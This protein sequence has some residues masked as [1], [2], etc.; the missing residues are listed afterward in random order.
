MCVG[1]PNPDQS[2]NWARICSEPCIKEYNLD[3]NDE[4]ERSAAIWPWLGQL[5][6]RRQQ[7]REQMHSQLAAPSQPPFQQ[8]R[9]RVSTLGQG[10][11][12]TLGQPQP[13]TPTTAISRER[14]QE[15]FARCPLPPQPHVR[16]PAPASRPVN[17]PVQ[18]HR[19]GG[20]RAHSMGSP[21]RATRSAATLAAAASTLPSIAA[22]SSSGCLERRS[23]T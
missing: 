22:E 17:R 1:L 10:R 19:F 8:E 11:V 7:T 2:N 23:A 6:V 9:G 20:G 4:G 16:W 12:S 3:V 21:V 13:P 14:T 18:N 15:V 5:C